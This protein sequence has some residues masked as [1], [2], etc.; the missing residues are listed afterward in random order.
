MAAAS[1]LPAKLFSVSLDRL[2]AS[3]ARLEA[4]RR[5]VVV[6]RGAMGS[7]EALMAAHNVT[8]LKELELESALEQLLGNVE[9]VDGVIR[10]L[11]SELGLPQPIDSP[12]WLVDAD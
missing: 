2:Q 4:M 8:P 3:R 11:E 10:T 5:D 12:V 1:H 7:V 6:I 9:R